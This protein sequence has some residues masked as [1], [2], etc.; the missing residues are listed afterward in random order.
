MTTSATVTYV[1]PVASPVLWE[2]P[3][4]RARLVQMREKQME[5]LLE[6]KSMEG[7]EDAIRLTISDPDV[8]IRPKA[9]ARGRGIERRVNCRRG[10]H[11]RYNALYLLVPIDYGPKENWVV[12]AYPSA[13]LPKGDLLYV[14][15]PFREP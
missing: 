1:V 12:T 10:A 3:D 5:H 13:N 11:S 15:I 14:R 4:G 7:E 6:H 9:R 8:V 2:V